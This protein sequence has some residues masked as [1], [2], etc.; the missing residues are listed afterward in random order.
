MSDV[1]RDKQFY[2]LAD[3]YIAVAN[4]QLSETKPSRVSA[5]AL[6]AASRFNAFVIAAAAGSKEQMVAEKE[7]AIAYFMDQY[8]KMLRENIDEHLARFDQ[9]AG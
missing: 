8:E 1:T 9:Q 5:A 2:D 3:A 4:T 6:F 7:A